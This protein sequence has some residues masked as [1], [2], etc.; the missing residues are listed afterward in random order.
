[1][2]T[3]VSLARPQQMAARRKGFQ[4]APTWLRRVGAHRNDALDKCPRR[5]AAGDI[6]TV[7]QILAAPKNTTY[8]KKSIGVK[9]EQK[10]ER[11]KTIDGRLSADDATT[12]LA[13]AARAHDLALVKPDVSFA[14]KE[15]CRCFANPLLKL[16]KR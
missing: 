9:N 2:A 15:L 6:S 11:L 5:G 16:L 14:T 12:V 7:D 1:M 8:K 13:L 3:I 10:L 4:Q